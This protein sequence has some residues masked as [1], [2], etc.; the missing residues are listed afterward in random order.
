LIRLIRLIKKEARGIESERYFFW[1]QE[2]KQEDYQCGN[3]FRF[4]CLPRRSRGFA[5]SRFTID[6]SRK[7][8]C[9]KNKRR[10]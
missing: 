1:K 5:V 4:H 10:A 3:S 6:H 8:G 7:R 9:I 2:E